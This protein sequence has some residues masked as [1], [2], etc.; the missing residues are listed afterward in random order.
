MEILAR[1]R[2]LGIAKKSHAYLDHLRLREYMSEDRLSLMDTF[3][4]PH[5][6]VWQR[7]DEPIITEIVRMCHENKWSDLVEMVL[8]RVGNLFGEDRIGKWRTQ[9][10]YPNV[11][12]SIG[13]KTYRKM[14]RA[15]F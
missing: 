10:V 3:I 9:F 14:K 4:L 6:V 7:A 15:L 11:P 5:I 2:V 12:V 8:N 13:M 1:L